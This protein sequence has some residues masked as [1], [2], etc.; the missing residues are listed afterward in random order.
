MPSRPKPNRKKKKSGKRT[1]GCP[2]CGR[3]GPPP[4][5]ATRKR[6]KGRIATRYGLRCSASRTKSPPCKKSRA[7]TSRGTNT[8]ASYGSSN[9]SRQRRRGGNA[10][11]FVEL[12]AAPLARS[13][14]KRDSVLVPRYSELCT[15]TPLLALRASVAGLRFLSVP[16]PAQDPL[17][18]RTVAFSPD[19]KLLAA[20]TGQPK[21]QGAVT[22]WN[23]ATG[24][25]IWKHSETNGVPCV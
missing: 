1:T 8:T 7:I 20:G 3:N 15:R 19:G 18:V 12:L 22:L 13:A 21:D 23:V 16:T 9:A 25:Q 5:S 6:K 4:S 2:S 14:S 17:G 10:T 24:K 11:R